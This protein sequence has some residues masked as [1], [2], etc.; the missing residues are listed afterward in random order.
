[1]KIVNLP[2]SVTS[3]LTKLNIELTSLKRWPSLGQRSQI[4]LQVAET[5]QF[6]M[7]ARREPSTK[8]RPFHGFGGCTAD[9]HWPDG[10]SDDYQ[11][12]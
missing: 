5:V 2:V 6:Q 7:I 11:T 1:M 10:K 9:V 3:K 12:H 8:I 4:V